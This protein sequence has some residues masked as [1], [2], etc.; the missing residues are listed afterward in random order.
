[1]GRCWRPFDQSESTLP[2]VHRTVPLP[3]TDP[4]S[5]AEL[6]A[7]LG[8]MRRAPRTR[9][10]ADENMEPWAL[11]ILRYRK[12]FDVIDC[13]GAR[14]RGCDDHAVFST[15]WRLRRVLITH[16]EDFLDDSNFPFFR[17]SGL[18]VFPTFPKQSW[19]YGVILQRTL[20]LIGRG[21]RLWSHTK[22]VAN[23]NF[24]VT[25][26]VWDKS[27]GKV[28]TYTTDVGRRPVHHS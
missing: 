23:R 26:R 11:Y 13:D 15:A 21:D 22:I 1:M 8:E 10:V 9:F 27:D 6:Q 14:V 12:R 2:K 16:D 28:S 4:L 5:G 25:T 18:V 20:N 7:V 24:T 17:C 3:D 19:D